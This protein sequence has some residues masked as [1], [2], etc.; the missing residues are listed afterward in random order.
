MTAYMYN[1]DGTFKAKEQYAPLMQQ[2]VDNMDKTQKVYPLTKDLEYMIRNFGNSQNWWNEG[3][4]GYLFEEV[5][6]VNP[7][8]AWMFLFCYAE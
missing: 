1:A 3:Q 4:P 8:N 5:S 6:G 2:Y 7:A